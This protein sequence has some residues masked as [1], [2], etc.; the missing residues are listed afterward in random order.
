[1]TARQDTIAE[2]AMFGGDVVGSLEIVDAEDHLSLLHDL[3]QINAWFDQAAALRKDVAIVVRH[4]QELSFGDDDIPFEH[5]CMDEKI[6][7]AALCDIQ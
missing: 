4:I 2:R 7:D 3:A 1:M 6:P 5:A